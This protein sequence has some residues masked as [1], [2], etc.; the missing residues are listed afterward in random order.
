MLVRL[1][2]LI[3]ERNADTD[4]FP[5]Q[6]QSLE[7]LHCAVILLQPRS[8]SGAFLLKEYAFLHE[9]SEADWSL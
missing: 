4:F 5:L 8:Q 6:D 2:L 7:L 3:L 1:F 9:I